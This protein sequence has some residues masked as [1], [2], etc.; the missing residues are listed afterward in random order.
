MNKIPIGDTW[1]YWYNREH[2]DNG[3][4]QE[5]EALERL[6]EMEKEFPIKGEQW[7]RE[8]IKK[9]IILQCKIKSLKSGVVNE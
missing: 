6:I 5:L 9:K 1:L 4:Y 7:L 2:R 8:S 3:F